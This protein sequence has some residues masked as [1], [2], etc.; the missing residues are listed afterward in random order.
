MAPMRNFFMLRLLWL[1]EDQRQTSRGYRESRP[2]LPCHHRIAL[3]RATFLK[4]KPRTGAGASWA[5]QWLLTPVPTEN[6]I[7]GCRR[8]DG[9]HRRPMRSP[10]SKALASPSRLRR[11]YVLARAERRRYRSSLGGTSGPAWR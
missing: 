8:F 1:A 10:W 3:N 9:R 6:L 7:M 5:G 4:E 11:H 2:A